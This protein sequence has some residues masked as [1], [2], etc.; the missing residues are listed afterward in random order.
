MKYTEPFLRKIETAQEEQQHPHQHPQHQHPQHQHQSGESY[1][2]AVAAKNI[3]KRMDYIY[4]YERY[5]SWIGRIVSLFKGTRI[6][7]APQLSWIKS[8][9]S[10]IL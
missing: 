9:V 6:N 1:R 8:K 5:T 4:R 7:G 10:Y 2:A 3:H